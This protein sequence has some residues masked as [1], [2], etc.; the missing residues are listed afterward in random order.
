MGFNQRFPKSILS[1][2]TLVIPIHDASETA[3]IVTKT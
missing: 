2:K 1:L 3:A